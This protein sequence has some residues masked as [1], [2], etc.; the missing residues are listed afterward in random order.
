[1]KNQEV[2]FQDLSFE[3]I[4]DKFY[5]GKK[6]R[7]FF[8]NGFGASVVSHNYSY[9]GNEG[10]YELAV[11]GPDGEIHYDNPIANGD[12]IGYLSEEGVTN[13]LNE[14]KKLQK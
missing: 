1:M 6:C 10:L 11:L 5:S 3:T 14:I 9:G 4:D 2:S 7:I 8:E 12:V 13:Y